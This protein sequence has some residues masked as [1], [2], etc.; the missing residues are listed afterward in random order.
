MSLP[1]MSK[2]ES[3]KVSHWLNTTSLPPMR[4]GPKRKRFDQR[5]D[6]ARQLGRE[7]PY[8]WISVR[9]ILLPK[10]DEKL[11]QGIVNG[12]AESIAVVDLL[13]P[14]AV[15]RVTEKTKDGKTKVR[16]VLVAGAHRLA[17]MKRLG[18]EKIPC[19]FVDGDEAEVQLVR[20]AEDLWRRTLT[21]LRRSEMLVEYVKLASAK[22]KVSGQLG[23][24]G[25]LGRPPSGIALAA[26]ELTMLGPTA[27]A[28]RKKIERAKKIAKIVPAAK[29]AA[30]KARLASNQSALSKIA[31]AGGPTAQLKM[32]AELA[33][34]SKKLTA[35]VDRQIKKSAGAKASKK[36][37]S[38]SDAAPS[39]TADP[40]IK[41]RVT[42]FDEMMALWNSHCRES[43]AYLP[44]RE[45]ERIIETLRRA[46]RRA[47]PDVAEFI[48]DVFRGREKVS[49]PALLGVALAHGVSKRLLNTMLPALR[50]RSRRRGWGAGSEWFV[51]NPD[52]NWKEQMHVVTNEELW[53]AG[54]A[55]R[56][57][58][59]ARDVKSGRYAG[60]DDYLDD[61]S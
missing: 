59:H 12:I 42:T 49:K 17:A 23:Q 10:S 9:K 35:P 44:V 47:R 36:T 57:A 38:R 41:K 33:E 21:V 50:Y 26:R 16:I 8:E 45:R 3:R 37:P 60:L 22:M 18:Q 13:H 51:W 54:D 32:V 2:E 5:V 43:W 34:I 27:D 24:K 29:K 14:I 4:W 28:R 52:R 58:R 48:K 6:Q 46:K 7:T 61:V 25:K 55:Q 53:A 39:S 11:D 19:I 1:R 30:I 56:N 20:L 15:R 31:K 40:S